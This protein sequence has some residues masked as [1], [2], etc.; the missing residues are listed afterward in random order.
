MSKV[1]I[2]VNADLASIKSQ[3]RKDEKFSQG[4]RLFAVYQIAA[5]KKTEDLVSL[6]DTSHKFLCN[7]IARYNAEGIEGLKDHPRAGRPP[8]LTD[9]QKAE[10]KAVVLQSPEQQGYNSGAWI[11]ALIADFIE[12]TFAVTYHKA[13]TYNILHSINLTY[14]K[15]KCYF[16]EAK[17]RADTIDAIKKTSVS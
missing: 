17:D 15:G 6:Y 14:Q 7:W 3:L 4:V 13:Q 8:K 10:L 2:R 11:W 9:E 16:P 5:G 12:K 1:R